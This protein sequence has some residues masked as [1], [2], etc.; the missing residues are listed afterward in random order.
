MVHSLSSFLSIFILTANLLLLFQFRFAA[1]NL[2]WGTGSK[3]HPNLGSYDN[4]VAKAKIGDTEYYVRITVQNGQKGGESGVHSSMVTN[5]ALYENPAALNS[6]PII[7]GGA[8]NYDRI[9]DAKLREFFESAKNNPENMSDY[10]RSKDS[11]IQVEG[12]VDPEA[13]LH[14]RDGEEEGESLRDMTIEE[15]TLKM[16]MMLADRHARTIRDRIDALDEI[17]ATGNET[18]HRCCR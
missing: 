14:F 15:Q 1:A 18:I 5:V 13:G 9:T 3:T 11:N 7:H 10:L 6:L 16:A 4:Y 8:V 2:R 17:I 12:I